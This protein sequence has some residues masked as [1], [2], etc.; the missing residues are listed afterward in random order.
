MGWRRVRYALLV[1]LVIVVTVAAG[2]GSYL[3]THGERQHRADAR[4]PGPSPAPAQLSRAT[5]VPSSAASTSA[6]VPAPQPLARELSAPLD[7]AAL[8]GRVRAEVAD[9]RTGTVL[10]HRGAHAPSAPASTAKLLT[11]VAALAS[12][13]A[14]HR[15]RTRV[16]AAGDGTVVLVGGGDPTL[17][18]ATGA[19]QPAYPDAARISDLA[20]QLRRDG[21]TVRR[22]VVDAN[23]FTGPAVSPAWAAEDVPSSYAS[24]I[25]ALMVDGGRA[26]PRATIRSA[27]P[28]LAAGHALAAAL[29]RPAIPVSRG[30]SPAQA[31]QLASVRSA[32]LQELIEQMLQNSDNVI[33][34][35][36]GRQIALAQHRPATFAGA[37]AAIRTALH[38]LGVDVGHGMRDASG[39][40]AA[41]R[42]SAAT[43]IS[44]LHLIAGPQHPQL[45]RIVTA[46]PVAAWSGTLADR[47][48]P[49]TRAATGAGVVRAKTGTLTGVSTLAGLVHDRD[50]RLLA[51]A[52]LADR[53]PAGQ[54]GT[55]AADA[56]LDRAATAL[57]GCGCR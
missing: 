33:A 3:V 8:G 31:R 23:L 30:H 18:A 51:F 5:A 48:L 6:A 45:N 42:L 50:G 22:I 9:A 10:Y 17:S 13:P 44:V 36:L 52:F 53:V 39:L 54:E 15:F 16:L 35:V 14:D 47:Y 4:R 11:A 20:G 41:D 57:A 32:P 56:A 55:D 46:L 28:D 40:A 34:E 12:Y 27:T 29:G 2:A 25:T 37:T 43:L 26:Q 24:P 38:E 7:A 21:V 1:L 49:G 19:Q